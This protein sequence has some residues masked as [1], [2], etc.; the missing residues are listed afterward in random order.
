MQNQKIIIGIG[1]NIKSEDGSHP[2]TVAMKQS[3]I[4][5]IIQLT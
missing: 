5:K 3:G 4:S 1:G 2:I